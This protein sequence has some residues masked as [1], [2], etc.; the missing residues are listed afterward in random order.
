VSFT[1]LRDIQEGEPLVVDIFYD[2]ISSRKF[3][4]NA[5]ASECL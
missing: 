3:V 2:V 5:F 1:A 4:S